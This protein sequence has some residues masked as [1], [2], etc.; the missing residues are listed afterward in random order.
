[1]PVSENAHQL[2]LTWPLVA[3]GLILMANAFF[4]A[5]EFALVTARRTRLE[6]AAT[7]GSASARLMLRMLEDPER[8]IAAAQVGITAAS[9]LLGIVAEEPLTELLAPL[10]T[11][12][13]G[14]FVNEAAAAGISGVFVLLILSFFHMVV[15]EQ[16]PKI[17]TIRYPERAGQLTAYPMHIFARV[18]APFVWIVNN[19]TALVLRLLGVRG[20]TGA[21]STIASI[22]ELKA[23]VRQSGKV[24]LLE[25]EAQEMVY[26]VFDF[27]ERVVREVM[28]PRTNIIGIESGATVREL[29]YIFK[30]HRY[31]RFPV[32]RDD[33]DH[34]VGVLSIKRLL[35]RLADD[36]DI[37]SRRIEELDMIREPMMVPESRLISD[38]FAEM[39]ATQTPLAIV[40]DEF[41]GTA[42]LVTI[43]ELVEEV[44][45]QIS[46][47]WSTQ[48]LMRQIAENVFE[49]DAQMDVDEVN[50]RLGLRL[51]VSD[52]YETIAG[53]ILYQLRRIPI[54]GQ[55]I[56]A[57][58][59]KIRVL[60]LDGPKITKVRIEA[61][62]P[63]LPLV[64]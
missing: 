57:A 16:T 8:A 11:P 62:G 40:I 13:L 60:E 59:Y 28:I 19:T 36:P 49:V 29:L 32:Y 37:L 24:G 58:G 44:M 3:M 23:I 61:T 26:R 53:L 30:N 41:G 43:G 20:T 38:L 1:M 52:E 42:G 56:I 39:R 34:I 55:E 4:V 47:E 21:H 6:Q 15:G 46:E 14:R 9:I 45:G 10:L 5:V 31:S 48:P 22:E 12:T 50:E 54:A 35:A 18:T 25:E 63:R 64:S 27:G 33:L 2:N 17:V 51:P 7:Q